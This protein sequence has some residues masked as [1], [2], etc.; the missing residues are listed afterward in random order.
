[1]FHNNLLRLGVAGFKV[2]TKSKTFLDVQQHFGIINSKG[3]VKITQ[4]F[5]IKLYTATV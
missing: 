4:N 2:V 1:M 5:D 3:Q